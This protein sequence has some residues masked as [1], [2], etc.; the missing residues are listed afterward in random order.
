MYFAEKSLKA[1]ISYDASLY[2]REFA[3]S[4]CKVLD[5]VLERVIR[6]L[7]EQQEHVQTVSDIRRSSDV[8]ADE[9]SAIS[10]AIGD[11]FG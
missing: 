2:S 8:S 6:F 11:L 1:G 9:M 10:D 3:E 7:T 5:T 4:F